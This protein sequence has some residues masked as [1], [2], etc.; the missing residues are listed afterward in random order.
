MAPRRIVKANF[1]G[2]KGYNEPKWPCE[3]LYASYGIIYADSGT[4]K[5]YL[6][7]LLG[8]INI[9]WNT[10]YPLI[11]R[12]YIMNCDLHSGNVLVHRDTIKL[13]D[14]GLSKRIDSL[15]A[16]SKQSKLFG[17]IYPINSIVKRRA[18]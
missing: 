18:L 16:P 4:I 2:M 13:A 14:F 5:N 17:V 11:Y 12:D 1:S 15:S 3:K 10:N 8:T 7:T 6:K 9:D